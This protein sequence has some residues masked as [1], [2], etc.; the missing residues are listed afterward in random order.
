MPQNDDV[1]FPNLNGLPQAH[2][3]RVFMCANK[4]C[5]RPHIVLF[6]DNG[7]AFAHFVPPDGP[8]FIQGLNAAVY[9]AAMLRD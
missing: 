7:K 6:D 4:S 8:G 5:K 1:P 2:S 3:V 9:H